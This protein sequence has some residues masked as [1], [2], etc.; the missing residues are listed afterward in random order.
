MNEL[1]FVISILMGFLIGTLLLGNLLYFFFVNLPNIV[2]IKLRGELESPLS[3]LLKIALPSFFWVVLTAFILLLI[4]NYFESYL[5]LFF[6]G[7]A[8]ALLFS[9]NALLKINGS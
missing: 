3:E 1:F 7:G 8:I 6:C 9:L 4:S 5:K 2:R